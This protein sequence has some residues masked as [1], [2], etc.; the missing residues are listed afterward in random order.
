VGEWIGVSG[1]GIR[2]PFYGSQTLQ[3][4]DCVT[5]ACASG[6]RAMIATGVRWKRRSHATRR[7]NAAGRIG[8]GETQG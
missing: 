4:H 2:T 1:N 8:L 3:E 6:T 7:P 5:I